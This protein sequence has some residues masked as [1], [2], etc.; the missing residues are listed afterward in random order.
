M[1]FILKNKK[2]YLKKADYTEETGSYTNPGRGWYHIYT[3]ALGETTEDELRYLPFEENEHI[4]LVLLKIG[5]Y[6][7]SEI[8]EE[9]LLFT[10]RILSAFV[11][12]GKEMILRILYDNEGK[13]MEKEPSLFSIIIRH[14]EQLGVVVQKYKEYILTTQGIFVGSWGEMH[15][16]KFLSKKQLIELSKT[17]KKASQLRMAFR[18]PVQCRQVQKEGEYEIGVFDDA[19]FASKS[20]L[21]TFGEQSKSNAGWEQPWCMEEEMVYIRQAA[22]KV[23]CGGEAVAG[24]R[25]FSAEETLRVLRDMNISY[26]NSVYDERILNRWKEQRLQEISLYDYIGNH[27]GYRFVVRNAV[28]AGR[29]ERYLNIIME[30]TG[31]ACICDEADIRLIIETGGEKRII[32]VSYDIRALKPGEK[33]EMKIEFWETLEKKEPE[34][35]KRKKDALEKELIKKGSRLYLEI[36]RCKDKKGIRLANQSAGEQM[37]LGE[38]E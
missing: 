7:T 5:R 34:K 37:L 4:A 6:S 31:F 25:E 1:G 32:P 26:L 24:E 27:M 20:H 19:M 21:G 30:N 2:Y 16:S 9:G 17:W 14:M 18:K 13:G 8:D 15:S 28:L 36:I 10:E 3:F 23:P 12:A 33:V 35:E 22:K 38:L 29:K 11:K